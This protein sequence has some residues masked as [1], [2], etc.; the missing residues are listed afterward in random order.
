[1][2]EASSS[3]RE[4]EGATTRGEGGCREI[5]AKGVLAGEEGAALAEEEVVALPTVRSMAGGGASLAR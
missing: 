5:H 1:M 2:P 4:R 3:E